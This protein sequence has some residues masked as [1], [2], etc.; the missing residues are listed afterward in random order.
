VVGHAHA[1]AEDG[2]PGHRAARV[3]GHHGHGRVAAA[4][5]GD[6]LVDQRGLA[7]AGRAGDAHRAGVAE[8]ALY[9]A[10]HALGVAAGF[11]RRQGAG[12]CGTVAAQALEQAGVHRLG[13]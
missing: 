12:Q 11:H 9:G 8:G 10:Q 7:G 3:D 13:G 4:Q 1:V 2:A 6:E 5:L